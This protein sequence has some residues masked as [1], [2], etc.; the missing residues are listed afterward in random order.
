M[1]GMP[2]AAHDEPSALW[3]QVGWIIAAIEEIAFPSRGK[4]KWGNDNSSGRTRFV[5][6]AFATG[7]RI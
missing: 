4:G 3:L 7:E 1:G 6:L 2:S 5:S